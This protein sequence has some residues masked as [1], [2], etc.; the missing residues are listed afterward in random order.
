MTDYHYWK[1]SDNKSNTKVLK[2]IRKSVVDEEQK[3]ELSTGT[4]EKKELPIFSN[5]KPV[6]NEPSDKRSLCNERMSSR[7][8]V[9]QTP[10]NPFLNCNNYVD[11][12]AV[13]DTMLRPRDS[14]TSKETSS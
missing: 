2:S 8:M 14:N 12:L 11:D 13:Q 9:I 5:I 1:W 6:Y 10:V 4:T 7:Y 3:E